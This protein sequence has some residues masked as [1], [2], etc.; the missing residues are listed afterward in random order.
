MAFVAK[1]SSFEGPL[2]LLLSLIEKRKLL[3]NEISLAKVADDFIVYV[4]SHRE[5]PLG[6]TAHFILIASTLLLIKS[7]SLLPNLELSV[8]ESADVASLEKRLRAYQRIKELSHAI[9]TRYGAKPLYP[10]TVYLDRAVVF[11]PDRRTSGTFMLESVRNVLKA[12]PVLV[13]LPKA[14]VKKVVSLEEMIERLGKRI[15]DSLQL[16]FREFAEV[17]KVEKVNVIVSFLALLELVKQGTISVLQDEH[18]EDIAIASGVVG[19]PK[20]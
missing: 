16:S 7:K 9:A 12:L 17:G 20:Y 13:E 6:E 2:D 14:I 10:R 1:T 19:T 3:I 4:Q 15:S 11:A 18:F 5:F 8:E